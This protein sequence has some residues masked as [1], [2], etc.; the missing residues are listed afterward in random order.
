MKLK[1]IS[2]LA[3]AL[4]SQMQARAQDAP[5]SVGDSSDPIG[6]V[7]VASNAV[8]QNDVLM[9]HQ[10]DDGELTLVGE[11]PTGGMGSG[12]GQTFRGDPL[13][14]QNSLIVSDDNRFVLV[15]NFLS[16]DV[17]VFRITRNGLIRTDVEKL[18]GSFPVSL[19]EHD[20]VVYALTL[21][22]GDGRIQGFSVK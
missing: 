18:G 16:H 17:S 20:G 14:S 10:G 21:D 8:P 1:I 3:L 11:F 7:F 2:I 9:Y 22:S 5:E 12:P 6:A 4:A 19:A 13:G 15:T